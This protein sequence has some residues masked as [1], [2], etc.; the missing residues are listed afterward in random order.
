MGFVF[1]CACGCGKK[2]RQGTR[3]EHGW[4]TLTQDSV[5]LIAENQVVGILRFANLACLSSWSD[6]RLGMKSDT[7]GN[8]QSQVAIRSS[9]DIV[10]V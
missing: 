6:K 8:L 2:E 7:V 3:R 5:N 9:G 10:N 1:V 4:F